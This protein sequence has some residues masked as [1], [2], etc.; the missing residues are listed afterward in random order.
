MNQNFKNWFLVFLWVGLIFILSHQPNLKSDLPSDWDFIL[1]KIAHFTEYAVLVFLLINALK[2]YQIPKR[3]IIWL[4]II[5]SILY[6]FSDEYH[7]SFILGR[8]A[9]LRDVGI[10]SLGVFLGAWLNKRKMIK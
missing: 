2:F 6:A 9:S 10:D 3:K 5:L 8:Q 4:S 7:Q 1:R